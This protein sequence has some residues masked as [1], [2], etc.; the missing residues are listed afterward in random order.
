MNYHIPVTNGNNSFRLSASG[1]QAI[2]HSEY[3]SHVFDI[4]CFSHLTEQEKNLLDQT[5][6]TITFKKGET[7]CKQ[8]S[9]ASNIMY[10]ENGLIKVY[11]E[12]NPNNLLLS[13]LPAKHFIGVQ[14][15]F[16]GNN[17]HLYSASSL[18]PSV[19]KIIDVSTFQILLSQNA[20]FSSRILIMMNENTAITYKRF[21][22]L[23]QKSLSSRLAAVLIWLSDGIFKNLCFELPLSRKEIG[24][25]TCMATESIIRLLKQ[26]SNDGLIEIKGKTIRLL[27]IQGLLNL[28]IVG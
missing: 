5:A 23:T 27:D 25:M 19:V 2:P 13:I 6:V 14:S 11:L 21:F 16:E 15:I 24:H 12:G 7:I 17:T 26:F 20:A 8:G 22:N 1:N 4:S 18:S 3:S 9:F 28:S 10:V